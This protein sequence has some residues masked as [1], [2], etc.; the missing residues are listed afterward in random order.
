MTELCAQVD[1]RELDT[2][3]RARLECELVARGDVGSGGGT[4]VRHERG[5]VMDA[6]LVRRIHVAQGRR[7]IAVLAD[8]LD[9]HVATLAI[10]GRVI[11]NRRTA[12]VPRPVE[13]NVLEHEKGSPAVF[14]GGLFRRRGRIGYVVRELY[15][16]QRWWS[17]AHVRSPSAAGNSATR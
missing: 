8:Q 7:C 3:R 2:G 12:A 9:H 4:H 10:G 6:E 14:A 15:G 1:H 11:E 16:L 5:H 17:V 13:R